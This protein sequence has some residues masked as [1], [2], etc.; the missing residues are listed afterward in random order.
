M[1]SKD[2]GYLDY[3]INKVKSLKL[4]KEERIINRVAIDVTYT[5]D[6]EYIK[7]IFEKY[8]YN[9]VAL[10]LGLRHAIT[11]RRLDIIKF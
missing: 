3:V 6:L 4:V 8:G 5:N 2:K 1:D 7:Y 9:H 11:H 10:S